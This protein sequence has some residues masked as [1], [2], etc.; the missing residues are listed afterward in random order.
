LYCE[1]EEEEET[2]NLVAQWHYRKMKLILGSERNKE[3]LYTTGRMILCGK[4]MITNC[5]MMTLVTQ[6]LMMDRRQS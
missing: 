6:G 5:Q 3:Q 4:M 2:S 1:V